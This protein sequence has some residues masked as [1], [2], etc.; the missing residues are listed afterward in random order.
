MASS[1]RTCSQTRPSSTSSSTPTG[2]LPHTSFEHDICSVRPE[3]TEV[4]VTCWAFGEGQGNG[5][6]VEQRESD[7]AK[8]GFVW[9]YAL[10]STLNF[11]TLGRP[12]RLQSG[13]RTSENQITPG[14]QLYIPVRHQWANSVHCERVCCLLVLNLVSSTRISLVLGPLNSLLPASRYIWSSA[15]IFCFS[16]TNKRHHHH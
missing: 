11:H 7:L 4:M 14:A 6:P 5:P 3:S 9:T 15:P 10:Y 1:S 12:D 16:R 2:R 8:P 13:V